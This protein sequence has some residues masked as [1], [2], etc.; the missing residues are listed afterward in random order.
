MKEDQLQK[1]KDWINSNID[2]IEETEDFLLTIRNVEV[3]VLILQVLLQKIQYNTN[4]NLM[5]EKVT[6]TIEENVKNCVERIVPEEIRS[7]QAH[8]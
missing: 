4:L 3:G 7:I 2:K 5:I 8:W 6:Q 1:N